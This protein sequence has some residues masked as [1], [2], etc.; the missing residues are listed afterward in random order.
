MNIF[1]KIKIFCR[2][3]SQTLPLYKEYNSSNLKNNKKLRELV[4]IVEAIERIWKE[5]Q[6]NN[7]Y[8]LFHYFVNKFLTKINIEKQ[9]WIDTIKTAEYWVEKGNKIFESFKDNPFEIT[10]ISE[11]INLYKK[12]NQI[13]YDESYMITEK[14]LIEIFKNRQKF[15]YLCQQ[16]KE[17]GKQGFYQE[18]LNYLYEALKI[19]K[20]NKLELQIIKFKQKVN[21]E[22][23]YNRNLKEI[24]HIAQQGNFVLAQ[25][26]LKLT[27]K[28]FSR[29]DGEELSAKL[30]RVIDAKTEY[31]QGLIAEK[32]DNFNL[33]KKQYLLALS[34]LPN[35]EEASYRLALIDIKQNN[36]SSALSYLEK[37]TGEKVNYLRGFC[38]LQKNDLQNVVKEWKIISHPL[39]DKN[40][41]SL[42]ILI[43][44]NRLQ[45]IQHIEN[46]VSKEKYQEAKNYCE[47]FTEKYGYDTNVDHNLTKHI[48][49]VLEHQLWKSLDLLSIINQLN[50]E[51]QKNPN[52]STLHNISIAYYYQAQIDETYIEK[53]IT[54]LMTSILNIKK[55]PILKNLSW[56]N[57]NEINYDK[58]KEELIK[59][60]ENTI[61]KYKDSNLKKYYELRDIFRQEMLAMELIG[62]PPNAGVKIKEVFI[63]PRFYQN[64]KSQLKNINLQKNKLSTLYTDFG[65]TVAACLKNDVE[66]A[67]KIKPN[68]TASSEVEKLAESLINYYEGC[69]HLQHDSWKKAKNCLQNAQNE[70]K[71]N[72]DWITEINRLCEKQRNKL[73]NLQENLEFGQFWYNLL[74]SPA[75]ASYLAEYKARDISQ[76]VAN[77]KI[78]FSQA[79]S[80]LKEVQ[81]IDQNNPLVTD[82]L[83]RL[84]FSQEGEEIDKLLKAGRFQAAV[85]K[86]KYSSN[87]EI[88][89]TVAEVFIK[90][91]IEGANAKELE[92]ETM[93]QFG[94]W[95]YEICPHEPDFR[96]IYKLLKII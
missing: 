48:Q 69:Y 7:K 83:N 81:K 34:Y 85:K 77:D 87:K 28:K 21:L 82:L 35:L 40:K 68:L 8:I 39:V 30:K 71:N 10:P 59:L 9:Q 84:E 18:G 11:A 73:D 49:P 76:Q 79:I 45:I 27:L 70:I 14:L 19:F 94:K 20:P 42:K 12:S 95:A 3:V 90:I 36:Y 92:W 91:I 38:Y 2:N 63:T 78:T 65:L 88:K 53:W 62:N 17:K 24:K 96:E 72:N 43:Q 57:I 29:Q 5:S 67:I 64:N 6:Y 54:F 50:Q 55:N 31:R 13:L 23:E 56:L 60:I 89:Y 75:S 66:R 37:L 46:S 26:Q 1:K 32:I 61:D 86:A 22:R 33:A 74:K 41:E 58:T 51:F 15:R 16:G 93:Q 52:I 80:K 25:T 44:R 47:N 4:I